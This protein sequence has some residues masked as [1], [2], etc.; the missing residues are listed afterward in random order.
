MTKTEL[1]KAVSAKTETT[2]ALAGKVI[3]A[4]FATLKEN[5]SK[6]EPFSVVGFGSFK[7][8][9]TSKRNGRNPRTGAEMVIPAAKKVRFS[10]GKG[11][12]DELN[13]KKPTKP[14]KGKK[15]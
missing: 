9:E 14:A 13:P 7:V 2:Q 15:K 5:F 12:K 1:V 4:V 3:D 6:G 10:M 8:V 11:L